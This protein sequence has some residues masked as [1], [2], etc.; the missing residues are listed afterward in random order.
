MTPISPDAKSK[1]KIT[2]VSLDSLRHPEKNPR[3]W[4]KEARQQLRESMERHGVIDPL[5][6]NNAEGREG[7]ILGGNFRFEILK[8]MGVTEIPVVYINVTDP[9]KE[10]E[11]ILRLNKNV[12]DWNLDLLAEYDT[13]L[14]GDVGFTSE[15]L[16]DIFPADENP[17]I[18]EL[19][20]ELKKLGI[21]EVDIKPG[22]MFE[23]GDLLRVRCGD[24]MNEEDVLALMAGEKADMCLTDEPYVLDYTRGKKRHKST[25]GFGYKRDRKYLGTDSLP[26]DFV[27]RWTANIA[28]VAKPDFSIIA[29]EHP[30]NLRLLWNEMEKYWRYR[31]T[32]IWHVPNRVQGFAAKY[33]FFNKFDIAYVGT[34]GDVTLN[35]EPE[36]DE[37]LQNEYEAALFMTSGKPHWESYEKGKKICPSDFVRHVASDEKNSG[38]SVI[39][40]TKP[41]EILIPY[42]KVLSKRGSLIIEP[43]GGSGSTGAAA[44]KMQRRCFMMEKSPTYVAVILARL[45][46]LSGVAPKKIL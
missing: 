30:K 7:V 36:A 22:D 31:G 17:E 5:L 24:S 40:G 28:K 3:T 46:K 19:E 45:S 11:I 13:S 32:I 39:F 16:D 21:S 34:S 33:K 1:L 43:F 37:L 41:V 6:C 26:D 29:Y 8:E 20:K 10:A 2:Y 35:A 42:I 18:F 38:Q 9:A 4:S 25:E 44:F 15:E 23:I 12:G 27:A 14:L